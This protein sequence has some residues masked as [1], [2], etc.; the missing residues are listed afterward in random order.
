M[1][2]TKSKLAKLLVIS[3]L[4]APFTLFFFAP[5]AVLAKEN[6]DPFSCELLASPWGVLAELA[7]ARGLKQLPIRLAPESE[8]LLANALSE[9]PVV[10]HAPHIGAQVHENFPDFQSITAVYPAAGFDAATPFIV[11]PGLRRVIAFDEHHFLD[12]TALARPLLINLRAP[13]ARV[14]Y[15]WVGT[16]NQV[17]Q[18]GPAIIGRLAQSI[19]GFR[20][21]AVTAYVDIG[22]G[23]ELVH[24][25]ILF[26]LGE[27]TPLQEYVHIQM[28]R[29]LR[30]PPLDGIP[31]LPEQRNPMYEPDYG[32]LLRIL[33]ASGFQGL[34]TKG[35]MSSMKSYMGAEIVQLLERNNGLWIDGD[36]EM[37]PFLARLQSA[38]PPR[39]VSHRVIEMGLSNRFGYHDQVHLLR[40]IPGNSTQDQPL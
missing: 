24:G 32:W 39:Q 15:T 34:L 19:P 8:A 21:R 37:H 16:V 33:R 10:P 3:L 20:V 26:D 7:S 35:S 13:E 4:Y 25:R 9:V 23:A 12:P 6:T 38:S 22:T 40:F 28:L 18:M 30:S 5:S 27:G 2:G 31:A 1:R 36:S 17:A 29:S 11:F 14:G